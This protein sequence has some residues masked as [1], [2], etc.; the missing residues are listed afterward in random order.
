LKRPPFGLTREAQHLVLAALVAQR[1]FD[2][3]TSSGNRINH[4]SLD[5]QIVWNDVVGLA[6]PAEET[7]SS[8]RLLKWAVL[9]TG[10]DALK[11]LRSAEARLSVMDALAAW[12]SRWQT[13]CVLERFEELPDDALN[14]RLYKTAGGVKKTFGQ[15]AA[16]VDG[17]RLGTMELDQCLQ[18]VADAFSDSEEE[19][20]AKGA[21]L[22]VLRDFL[23]V[24]D[25][26]RTINEYLIFADSAGDVEID[27]LRAHLLKELALPFSGQ[28][29]GKSSFDDE[30]S[31]FKELYATRYAERHDEVMGPIDSRLNELFAGQAWTTFS[32]LS[33]MPWF[34]SR[35]MNDARKQI[36]LIR[37]Q[38]CTADVRRWLET[39]PSCECSFTLGGGKEPDVLLEE[40]RSVVNGALGR[41]R[42]RV[43]EKSEVSGDPQPLYLESIMNEDK[44][45]A[46]TAIQMHALKSAAAELSETDPN[47][48]DRRRPRNPYIPLHPDDIIE[49]EQQ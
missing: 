9:L 20:R 44:F 28:S 19:F 12:L 16:A 26:R 5:L 15:A 11:T 42:Q 31:R 2:F 47:G 43:I 29:L 48:S 34:G 27:G 41:F 36:R 46:M 40:L 6:P 22:A 1:E 21:D 4:R 25:E 32:E 45:T 17:L 24:S 3:V 38:Q 49:L 10:V 18:A 37:S 23:S 35:D 14:T 39:Q 8:E 13:D 30:W 33:A 7:Y